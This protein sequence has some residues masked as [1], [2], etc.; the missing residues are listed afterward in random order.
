MGD[1]SQGQRLAK[2]LSLILLVIFQSCRFVTI[3]NT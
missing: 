3:S 2:K 1:G